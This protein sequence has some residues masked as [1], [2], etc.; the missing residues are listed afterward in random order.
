MKLAKTQATALMLETANDVRAMAILVQDYY[1]DEFMDDP[2][3]EVFTASEL[4]A[5]LDTFILDEVKDKLVKEYPAEFSK[6][7]EFVNGLEDAEPVII[8]LTEDMKAQLDDILP[9]M[10]ED[11]DDE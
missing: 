9:E 7:S 10:Y 5:Y 1:E 11:E 8:K 4:K 6:F 2:E 3:N